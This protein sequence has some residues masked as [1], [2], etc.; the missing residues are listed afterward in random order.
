[1]PH[2]WCLGLILGALATAG[3]PAGTD[4]DAW[5]SAQKESSRP[6]L[7]RAEADRAIAG[8]I[9][10]RIPP[11]DLRRRPGGL[12]GPGPGIGPRAG[13]LEV[14]LAGVPASIPARSPGSRKVALSS[15]GR[16]LDRS[17]ATRHGPGSGSRPSSTRRTRRPGTASGWRRSS[18]PTATWA[19]PGR[20]GRKSR[21]AAST[22]PSGGSSP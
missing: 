2:P 18:I 20:P 16:L 10:D 3:E 8:M 12:G 17:S 4:G 5:K 9:R 11:L 21:S 15:L 19:P 14:I 22:S 6:L 7:Q 13:P 1:M